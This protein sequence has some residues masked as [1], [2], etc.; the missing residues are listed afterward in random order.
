[1][2]KR[3]DNIVADRLYLLVTF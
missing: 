1:L 2:P 3:L